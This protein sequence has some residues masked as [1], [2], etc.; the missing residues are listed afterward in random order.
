MPYQLTLVDARDLQIARCFPA[1][2]NCEGK[3]LRIFGGRV[4]LQPCMGA[5]TSQVPLP[6]STAGGCNSTELF[7]REK[8][9]A[10]WLCFGRCRCFNR[11]RFASH[12]PG[13]L[14]VRRPLTRFN[15]SFPPRAPNVTASG[16]DLSL[17]LFGSFGCWFFRGA[18][19]SA[20]PRHCE[21]K[22]CRKL[23]AATAKVSSIRR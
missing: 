23:T 10:T 17:C 2:H 19:S 5:Q 9:A 15:S 13:R 18:G 16:C 12:I 22:P 6:S 3:Q 1:T 4:S 14:N 8:H 21:E 11:G 7:R 20:H